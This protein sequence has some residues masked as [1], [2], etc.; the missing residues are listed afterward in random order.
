MKS[1]LKYIVLFSV[2]SLA[3]YSCSS[4]TEE[5]AEVEQNYI[6]LDKSIFK[7]EKMRLVNLKRT[8]FSD[9]VNCTGIVDVPPQNRALITAYYG[10]Y[11]R[12]SKLLVGD[13]VRKGDLLV[14]IDHPEYLNIQK[15]YLKA[16]ASLKSLK[17]DYERQ[18]ELHRDSISSTKN[19]LMAKSAYE[20][21]LAEMR[22]LEE[23]LKLLNI[24]PSTLNQNNIS[25]KISIYAPIDGIVS[26]V[27]ISKGTYVQPT[28]PIM[29]IIDSDHMHLELDVFEKDLMKLR[30]GQEIRFKVPES[31]DD[32][33]YGDVH[34]IGNSVDNNKR[35]VKVHGHFEQSDSIHFAV[36]MFIE[37]NIRVGEHQ[38][39]AI[40]EPAIHEEGEHKFVLML[41][42]ETDSTFRF[43]KKEV[44][45][46][47][48]NDS[49]IA[50]LK[51]DERHL[52]DRFLVGGYHLTT[53]TEAGGHHH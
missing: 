35:T 48:V 21:I 43:V 45:L 25:A 23:Q 17:A 19:Y 29:E 49:M 22:N 20:N 31:G 52:N 27:N 32:Y 10:G 41:E 38:R 2:I 15:N 1:R 12:Q 30:K 3:L 34:L 33:Y 46:G 42:E 8:S 24:N 26:M 9:W 7:S 18:A 28:N 47:E 50:I 11:I 44:E 6:E 16:K 14:T 13:A 40:Q 4:N 36:G 53:D 51:I 39:L 37:A 5:S